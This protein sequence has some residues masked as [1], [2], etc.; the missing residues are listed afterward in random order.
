MF[1]AFS[2]KRYSFVMMASIINFINFID[3]DYLLEVK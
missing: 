1:T 3:N 2:L